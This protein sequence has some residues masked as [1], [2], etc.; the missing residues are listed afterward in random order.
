MTALLNVLGIDTHYGDS[1]V[2][3]G[4]S[5]E[6]AAGEVVAVLGRNGVGKTTLMRSI[7]GFTPPRSGQVLFDGEEVLLPIASFAAAWRWCRRGGGCFLR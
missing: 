6:V 4:L 1:H 2:L 7:V 3:H 5:L